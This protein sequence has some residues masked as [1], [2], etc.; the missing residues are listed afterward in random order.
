MMKMNAEDA[1]GLLRETPPFSCLDV[2]ALQDI[3]TE[4]SSA[5]YP[6]GHT[7]LYQNGPSAEHLSIIK[8]GAVKVFVRTNEGEEVLVDY[9]TSRDFFGLLSFLCGDVSMDYVV[10]TEDTTCCLVKKETVLR[11]LKT[12]AEFSEFFLRNLVKRL[13]QMTYK[14]I[15]DRTLLYGGGDKLLF[16]NILSDLATSKVITA[17]EDISIREAAEIMAD[18]KVSSLVLL[19]SRGL[20]AG[21]ITD[22]DLRDKVVSKGRD[23]SGRVGDVMSVTVIK[24]GAGDY[25]FEALQKM[26]R[27][28]IHH[29]LVVG[30]GEMKG[31]LT[32]HDL[33]VLQ[34]SSPL[35]VAR[36]IENQDTIDG[37]VPVS[38]KM[39]KLIAI[40]IREG[41]KASNITRIITE[42]NDRLLKKILEI[43]EARLGPPPLSY[44]WIVYGSEGRKEQTFKTDQDN[45]IIYEDPEVSGESADAYFTEFASRMKDALVLCGFPP[46]KADYMAS[47]PRWRQP[48]KVWKTYFSDWINTPTPEAVLRSLIFFDFRPV[49]GN[50]LLAEKLRAFL[51]R[52]IKDKNAFLGHMAGSVAGNKPPLDFFGRFICGKKGEHQ[53]KF[54][55]KINGLGP[56]IDAVRL[57]SLEMKV[58][59]TSTLERLAELK[60]RNST[61]SIFCSEL[62]H[63]FE[64]LMSLRLR[65]QIQQ[66]RQNAEPDNFIN[67]DSLGSMERTLLKESFKLILSVQAA[68]GKKYRDWMV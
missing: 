62:E 29:L 5:V 28:N 1:L 32:G 52:E 36:E 9:R 44:C 60:G 8:S 51:G 58:Y 54:D 59:N 16:T 61:V 20:P 15:H 23:I 17:S 19:D 2:P 50:V 31:I 18:H 49:H 67:P 56:L 57:S 63:A 25:C 40:L 37:L 48:L 39:D 45:A 4:V 27:Y 7:I 6:K 10:S 66:M 38:K 43:T 22:R 21:M 30:E 64:F 46:C 11:L 41:A 55:I 47:N 3:A 24:S 65:R 12:N 33:M 35:A 34:G 26:L 13:V 14:E 68:A 42:I 53:G